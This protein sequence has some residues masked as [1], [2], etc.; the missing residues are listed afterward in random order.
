M[1]I[2]TAHPLTSQLYTVRTVVGSVSCVPSVMGS[3]RM[4][5]PG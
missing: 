3:S 4:L 5:N 1:R 2:N